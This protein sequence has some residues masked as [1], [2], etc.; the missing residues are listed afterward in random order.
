MTA[1]LNLRNAV[2]QGE[3]LFFQTL[4]LDLVGTSFGQQLIDMIIER[5]MSRANACQLRVNSVRRCG[6]GDRPYAGGLYLPAV[7]SRLAN[8]YS[9]PCVNRLSSLAIEH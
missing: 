6:D 5:T 4:K 3:F 1:A 7:V 8:R 9:P 2:A